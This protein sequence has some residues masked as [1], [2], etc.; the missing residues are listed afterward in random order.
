M[1]TMSERANGNILLTHVGGDRAR[2]C[3]EN[4]CEKEYENKHNKKRYHL[5][6]FSSDATVLLNQSI[7]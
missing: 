7:V 3:S 4:D 2:C 5:G 1:A 6:S